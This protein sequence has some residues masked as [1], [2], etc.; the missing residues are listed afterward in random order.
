MAGLAP[1]ELLRL[2]EENGRLSNGLGVDYDY[3]RSGS[4]DNRG[5]SSDAGKLPWHPTFST[6]S[7]YSTP[8]DPGGRWSRDVFGETFTPSA[9]QQGLAFQEYMNE[10]EPNVRIVKDLPLELDA[11]TNRMLQERQYNNL[12]DYDKHEMLVNGRK[13]QLADEPGLIDVS[14]SFVPGRKFMVAKS[15]LGIDNIVSKIPDPKIWNRTRKAKNILFNKG[16]FAG[17]AASLVD[18][19]IK[20]VNK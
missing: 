5:H 17:S 19:V 1:K 4:V 14:A 8:R 3:S 6:Q 10:V 18:E 9:K 13:A 11:K 2:I 12:S 7:D 16:M 15:I 20:R